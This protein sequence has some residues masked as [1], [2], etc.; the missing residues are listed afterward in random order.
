MSGV[1]ALPT[2]LA[3]LATPATILPVMS[4]RSR[5]SEASQPL[6]Y[7]PY[8]PPTPSS[9]YLSSLLRLSRLLFPR[10]P[11]PM[12]QRSLCCL[13]L[14]LPTRSFCHS[15]CCRRRLPASLPFLVA[16]SKLST[17]DIDDLGPQLAKPR[18]TIL[19]WP[20]HISQPR[21]PMD[22]KSIVIIWQ[23]PL[24]KVSPQVI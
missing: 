22:T 10:R 13:M 18:Y 6:S 3:L 11:I 15:H 7:R 17:P 23:V 14:P 16:P 20:D 12:S 1:R 8:P 21:L 4:A 2:W 5:S 24:S 9:L 19:L